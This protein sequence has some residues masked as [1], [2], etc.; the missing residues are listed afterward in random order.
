MC[1]ALTKSKVLSYWLRLSKKQGLP[2]VP[3]T[4]EEPDVLTPCKR[5]PHLFYSTDL[6]DQER[7]KEMC[8]RCPF[9][10]PCLRKAFRIEATGGVWG[11]FD[12]IERGFYAKLFGIDIGKRVQELPKAL[13]ASIKR[14]RVMRTG[15]D[16][17]MAMEG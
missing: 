2:T 15:A 5:S 9:R 17:D 10:A 7:A 4:D 1:K 13:L 16:L 12:E 6:V 3:S 8:Q 11:G 14:N